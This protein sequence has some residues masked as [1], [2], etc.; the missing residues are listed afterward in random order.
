MFTG[1]NPGVS[2]ADIAAVTRNN[3][4]GFGDGNGWWA[5]IL[6]AILFGWGGNGNFGP[7][8]CANGVGAEV[9]RGFDTQ[10]ITSKLDGLNSGL[11]SLGYDQL[12]QMNQLGNLITGTGYNVER[13]IQA[14]TIANMQ[15]QFALSRQFD[16]C[17]CE[18]KAQIADLKYDMA[19]SDCGIKTLIGQVAQQL[20]WGQQSNYRDLTELINNQ[21]CQL[22]MEQKDAVIAELQAKLNGCDRDTALQSMATYIIN[23]VRPTPVPA[24]Q[25]QNPWAGCGCGVQTGCCNNFGC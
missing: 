10:A 21:F 9:Q 7:N 1:M 2:L 3:N 17:C 15:N 16:N 13:A 25:V 20:Q 5:W 6:F 19:T 8:G 11:C 24:W 23:Q 14:D 4:D 12:A 22:R 18:T